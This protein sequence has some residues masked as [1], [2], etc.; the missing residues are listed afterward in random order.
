MNLNVLAQLLSVFFVVAL[1]PAVIA[2]LS[3]KKVAL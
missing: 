3:Y 1:G 2:F